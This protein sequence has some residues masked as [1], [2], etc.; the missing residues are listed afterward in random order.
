M[1]MLHGDMGAKII[2]LHNF[3]WHIAAHEGRGFKEV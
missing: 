2:A 3:G 1:S